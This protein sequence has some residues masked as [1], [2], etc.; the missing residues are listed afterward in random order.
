MIS[1]ALNTMKATPDQIRQ[2]F[3]SDV[4]RF[5]NLDTGQTSTIDAR[6]SLELISQAAAAANPQ[7]HS[8]L[9]A[10]CGAGNYTLKL[11]EALPGLEVTLLDLSRPM[12]DR[13][14]DRI[15]RQT[16]ARITAMQG[17]IREVALGEARFDLI[18][19]GGALH[20][21]RAEAEW[22]SV[23]QKFHASL[24]TG[25]SL[26]VVDF[27]SHSIPAVQALMWNRYGDYL[28]QLKGEEYRKQVFAYIEF[29]D[30]PRPLLFQTD[31]LRETGFSQ[32][33]VLHKNTC[34]AAF[35]AVK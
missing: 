23:F 15:A 2:R 8:L 1:P 33:E 34:F 24:K 10:G 4:E 13:A 29:E 14:R 12:L 30:S 16:S 25:G 32:I 20:H 11:L 3:D 26:W 6:L 7:A 27:V 28:R 19:S 5:S 31:L 22:R 21:L 35:G 17:D 18:V 9:D